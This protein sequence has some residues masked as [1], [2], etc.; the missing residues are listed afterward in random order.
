MARLLGRLAARADGRWSWGSVALYGSLGGA[1]ANLAGVVG[2]RGGPAPIPAGVGIAFHLYGVLAVVFG[3]RAWRHAGLDRRTRRSWAFATAAFVLL[4]ASLILHMAFPP[5]EIFPAPGDVLRLLFAPVLLVGLLTLPRRDQGRRERQKM[6]FDTGIV[7]IASGMLLWYLV[8]GPSVAGGRA[9]DISGATLATAL[10]YPAFDLVLIFGATVVVF[11]G[12]ADSA[13]RPA[14]LLVA[15]TL[16]F[17]VGDVMLGYQQSRGLNQAQT[18]QFGCWLTGYFLVMLAA[19]TQCRQAAVH[20]LRAGH[21][22]V[23]AASNLPYAAIALGYLLLLLS[24]RG[25]PPHVTGVVVGAVAITTVVVMRQVVALREN[26]E[27]ATTDGLT[28]LAN[29]RQFHDILRAALDRS[30]RNGQTVAAAVMDMNGFK[31]LNDT[32]GHDAGDRLLVAIGRLLR[33]NVLGLDT[34]GRLGGD[35]FAIVLHDIRVLENASSV[36][37]RI[38]ADMRNPV[39]IGDT[40]VQPRGSIGVAL[41]APGQLTGEQL[42]HRADLAMYHAKAATRDSGTTHV[43]Y[44]DPTMGDRSLDAREHAGEAAVNP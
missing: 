38:I 12:A 43:A 10:A 31:Q 22:R 42:L 20:R 13:R 28:G 9:G 6:W 3:V 41:S 14:T 4:E 23:R 30:A 8:V 34:V 16:A 18:W 15:A 19:F 25:L 2:P 36:I 27:L 29:R 32:M 7:V 5:G 40:P 33:R 24:T 11:R 44:Y 17:V 21:S 39:L 37:E 35:E 1:L 26:H